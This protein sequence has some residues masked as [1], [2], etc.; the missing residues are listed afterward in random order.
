MF[1]RQYISMF[2]LQVVM[3]QFLIH[4][5]KIVLM[6]NSGIFL[7]LKST[8]SRRLGTG[9]IDLLNISSLADRFSSC[10]LHSSYI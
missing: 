10:Q 8:L 1:Q 3:Y 5:E 2:F 6:M 4:N 7:V 9:V